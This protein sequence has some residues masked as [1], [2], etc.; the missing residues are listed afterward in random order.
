MFEIIRTIIRIVFGIIGFLLVLRFVFRFLVA[1]PRTPFVAWLYGATASL[2]SPFARILPD[3]RLGNF[4]VDF[5]TLTALIV[6]AIVGYL[7]LELFSY[8]Q[9][10]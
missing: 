2:V 6:Y 5:A 4:L 3:L 10:R 1:N 8:I 9:G 7:I